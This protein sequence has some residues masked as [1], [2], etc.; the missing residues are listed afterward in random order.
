MNR[1]LVLLSS[2]II[3]TCLAGCSPSRKVARVWAQQKVYA[4]VMMIPAF[5][6][7][8]EYEIADGDKKQV[9]YLKLLNDTVVMEKLINA[10]INRLEQRGQRVILPG[11][12]ESENFEGLVVDMVQL[13]LL[14]NTFPVL[15]PNEVEEAA[16]RVFTNIRLHALALEGWF[17]LSSSQQ[18]ATVWYNR[19]EMSETFSGGYRGSSP[20]N[21]RF[22]HRIDKLSVEQVYAHAENTGRLWADYFMDLL[23]NNQPGSSPYTWYHYDVEAKMLR[24]SVSDRFVPVQ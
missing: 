15:E 19:Q 18:T 12:A 13:K 4:P 11:E 23:M 2:F 20:K 24:R 7:M 3:M 8:M 14:E 6:L 21:Y 22:S 1:L 16:D 10:F 9:R 5:D 17:E